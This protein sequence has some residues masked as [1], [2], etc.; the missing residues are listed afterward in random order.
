MTEASIE[1]FTQAHLDGLIA[2]VTAEGWTE[3]TNDAKR[4]YRAL[5]APGVTTLVAIVGRRVVGAIQLQSDGVIQAHVSMLL[6]DRNC[7]GAQLGSK[8]LREGLERAGGLQLDI[9]TRTEGYYERFGASRSLGFRLT[10][11]DLG[12]HG[13]D[14]G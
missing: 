10:R 11:E 6:I 1:P 12:L 5:T 4:T 3:Y 7:R 14:A 9:R 13:A 8:L 2:L